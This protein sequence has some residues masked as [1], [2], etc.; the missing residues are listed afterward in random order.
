MVASGYDTLG[1][2]WLVLL[3]AL[4]LPCTATLLPYL[5]LDSAEADDLRR[6]ARR[7]IGQA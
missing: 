1:E 5:S 2:R 3:E 4:S 6:R 7:L